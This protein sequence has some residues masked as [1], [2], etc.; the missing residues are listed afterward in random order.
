MYNHSAFK[1]VLRDQFFKP[2]P[3]Q[4]YENTSTSSMTDHQNTTDQ[5]TNKNGALYYAEKFIRHRSVPIDQYTKYQLHA[6][7]TAW[8]MLYK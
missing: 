4:H 7:R 6:I 2:V 1:N 8:G 3:G 5:S